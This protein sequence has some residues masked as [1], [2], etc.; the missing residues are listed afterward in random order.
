MKKKILLIACFVILVAF[1]LPLC[2]VKLC[3][4][5]FSQLGT[6]GDFF[7]SFNSLVSLLA[8]GGLIY[9]IHLQREDLKLQRKELEL[10]REELKKQA[11]AQE[12]AAAEQALQAELL[13]EQI[14]KDIRPYINVFW[15]IKN[16]A[17]CLVI[18]NVG[19]STCSNFR[20]QSPFGRNPEMESY[21]K[22][23]VRRVNDFHL[24]IFPSNEEYVIPFFDDWADTQIEHYIVNYRDRLI[25]LRQKK[26]KF[27]VDVSFKFKQEIE[28]FGVTFDFTHIPVPSK[29]DHALLQ[30]AQSLNQ[31][32]SSIDGLKS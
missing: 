2:L 14:N 7:G 18:R 15:A 31:I 5:D 19:K 4:I 8:F 24:D 21:A 10:T 3:G 20:I 17:V 23:F 16:G 32:K 12:K 27:S 11:E 13:A 25:E 1:I 26:V 6:Y 28:M 30:I 29:E 22:G 9:T